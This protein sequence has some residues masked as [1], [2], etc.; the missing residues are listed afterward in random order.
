GFMFIHADYED[1]D[2]YDPRNYVW[3]E[4]N[5]TYV[6][7]PTENL[8]LLQPLRWLGLTGIADA[9]N[10]PLKAIVEQ[11]YD[12]SYLPA[13]PGLPSEP[14]PTPEP[15]PEPTPEPEPEPE[16]TPEPEEPQPD[17]EPEVGTAT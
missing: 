12:R 14:E 7:V 4:G 17:P 9:L 1:V 6:F 3:T 10:E 13:E 2:L 11:A 8:P 16:P 5:T 15:E